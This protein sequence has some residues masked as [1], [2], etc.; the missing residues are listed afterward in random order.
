MIF[1]AL[2]SAMFASGFGDD[3]DDV[4]LEY[5]KDQGMSDKE[6]EQ[7]MKYYNS[8]NSKKDMDTANS[9]LDNILR[10]V[11]VQGVIL[12]TAK[13]VLID[14]YRRSE[15]EGQYP[16]P[17]YGDNTWKLLEVSPPISIKTKKY[18]GGLRDYEINLLSLI[19]KLTHSSIIQLNE[20]GTHL[21]FSPGCVNEGNYFHNTN[22]TRS[23]SYY[24]EFLIYLIPSLQKKM[25]VK[26]LG[27]R[28]LKAEI[29][30]EAF[31]ASKIFI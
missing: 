11:G 21:R 9:M 17:E 16:G 7:A 13:N 25:N 23:L 4:S 26:L 1:T 18:K 12:S 10:G 8:K 27:V 31:F 22:G 28:S 14:L 5:F 15:K 6:A 29:S 2:Q 30:L 20:Q 24:L 3:E 19:D